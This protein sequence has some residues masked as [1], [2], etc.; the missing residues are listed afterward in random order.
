[1]TYPPLLLFA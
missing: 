1:M